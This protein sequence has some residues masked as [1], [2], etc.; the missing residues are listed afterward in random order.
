MTVG[1]GNGANGYLP[2][3]RTAAHNNNA[4]AVNAL[5]ALHRL[6]GFDD[7]QISQVALQIGNGR[8]QRDFEVDARIFIAVFQ[9][10]D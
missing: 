3:L 8:G 5:E 6:D 4:L 9:D 2:D 7:R 1:F 10:L